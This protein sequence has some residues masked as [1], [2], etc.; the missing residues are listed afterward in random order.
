MINRGLQKTSQYVFNSETGALEKV[1]TNTQTIQSLVNQANKYVDNLEQIGQIV[2]DSKEKQDPVNNIVVITAE[3]NIIHNYFYYMDVS[4]DASNCLSSAI[5]KMPKID[6]KNINYWSTYTGQLTIY[7]GYNFK[8]DKVNSQKFNEEQEAVNSI[9]R[10]WDNSNITPFFR[11]EVSRIKETQTE[12]TIYVDSI[13]KRFQQKIPEDFRQAYIY[14]QNVRDAF[15]AICEFLGVKYICP[16]KTVTDNG[17]EEVEEEGAEG[18]GDENNAGLIGMTER[19]ISSTVRRIVNEVNETAENLHENGPFGGDSEEE[20]EEGDSEEDALTNNEEIEQVQNGYGDINFDANGAIVHGSTVIETSPDMAETLIAMD[21]NP[22][23]KY[24]EDETGIVEDVLALL[25]G[26][27]FE[28]LHNKVMNYDSITIEPKAAQTTAMEGMGDGNTETT[29]ENSEESSE[30]SNSSSGFKW[31][32]M[33]RVVGK[34]FNKNNPNKNTIIKA[35]RN[36][37]NNWTCIANTYDKYKRYCTAK[38]KNTVIREIMNC[39]G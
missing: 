2:N 22:L 7:A 14:N 6:T 21:E 39:F 5:I 28:E 20:N 16:P 10:Y 4:W 30:S 26:D 18:D 15:Q 9:S 12:I 38:S 11:G 19:R 34:Y 1:D 36:C 17:E 37:S 3:D 29:G 13:G 24:L 25:N 35:F 27:M 31:A 32:Q 33:S 23:E 8:F